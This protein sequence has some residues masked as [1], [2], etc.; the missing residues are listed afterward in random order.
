[1]STEYYSIDIFSNQSNY[2]MIK[3]RGLVD[4]KEG[5]EVNSIDLVD[6]TKD[7]LNK[8]LAQCFLNSVYITVRPSE[9][10]LCLVKILD[11]VFLDYK[12][13]EEIEYLLKKY[14]V[15]SLIHSNER[16]TLGQYILTCRSLK[17][18]KNVALDL[19]KDIKN[20]AY[21]ENAVSYIEEL[22]FCIEHSLYVSRRASPIKRTSDQHF[23]EYCSLCWRLVDK[24]K[25]IGFSDTE[26]YSFHYCHEHHPSINTNAYHK[27]RNKL[28]RAIKHRELNEE[29]G[30]LDDIQK[31]KL[32]RDSSARHVYRL[33]SKF[34]KK[35][36]F[37]KLKAKLKSKTSWKE[38]AQSFLKAIYPYYPAIETV[39][40]AKSLD[41]CQTWED[42]FLDVVVTLGTSA[43]LETWNDCGDIKLMK[44]YEPHKTKDQNLCMTIGWM[45]LATIFSRYQAH[46]NIIRLNLK[47]GPKNAVPASGLKLRAQIKIMA[48]NQIKESG[49]I[50]AAELGR[51]IGK[52][53]ERVSV[54]LKELGLR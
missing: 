45:A 3:I 5:C 38:F 27:V 54:L 51:K 21:D 16:C 6:Q 1:M 37:T 19:L 31:N 53:R 26:G 47:K 52:S 13:F 22:I 29:T 40:Y 50:N 41:K 11:S 32:T 17:K 14:K 23:Q 28:F 44:T 35:P 15:Q 42:W 39:L 10:N 34:S 7:A 25:L 9:G 36:P 46:Q 48:N 8:A 20:R 43:D 2:I 30:L 18:A 12:F 24:H 33:L 4:M 49:K